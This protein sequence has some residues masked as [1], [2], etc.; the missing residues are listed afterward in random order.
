MNQHPKS[1]EAAVVIA[2]G[3]DKEEERLIQGDL[4]G[5]AHLLGQALS[6]ASAA[7]GIAARRKR[8]HP[9]LGGPISSIQG[10]ALDRLL[11]STGEAEHATKRA[12]EDTNA[13]RPL[14]SRR[15]RPLARVG[16]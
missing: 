6:T 12:L 7:H 16:P 5:V 8:S 3:R 15:Y 2:L 10:E 14:L 1:T 4:A 13:A 11:E 9:V